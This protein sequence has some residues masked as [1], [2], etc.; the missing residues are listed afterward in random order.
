MAEANAVDKSATG[1]QVSSKALEIAAASGVLAIN[2][3]LNPASS[4][5][6]DD[7]PKDLAKRKNDKKHKKKQDDREEEDKDLVEK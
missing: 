2:T 3:L 6:D 7:K 5:P 1:E 4:D